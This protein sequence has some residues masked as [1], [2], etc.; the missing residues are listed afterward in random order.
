MPGLDALQQRLEEFRTAGRNL[1]LQPLM[2]PDDVARFRVDYQTE[3]VDE[4][5]Q[6]IADSAAQSEAGQDN[7]FI[8]TGHTGCGKSTLLAQVGMRLTQSSDY[9]IVMFSIA[10]MIE[11]SAVDHVN[12]LFSVAVQ[13]LDVAEQRSVKLPPGTKKELYR[14]LGEHAQ[15]ESKSVVDEIE[16]GVGTTVEG[17]IPVFFKFFAAIKNT[18]KINSLVRNDITVKFARKISELVAKINEIQAYVENAVNK[19]ILVII[20]DLDKLDLSVT[21]T[22]FSKNIRALLDPNLSIVYTIPIATLRDVAVKKNIQQ[23]IKKIHTM[24][25]AKFFKKSEVRDAKR[26]PDVTLMTVFEEILDRRLPDDLVEPG[27]KRQMILKS[28]GVLRELMRIADLCCDRAL[29]EIR[30]QIRKA[31][32]DQPTVLIDALILESVLTDMQITYSESLGQ[33]DYQLLKRIYA[34]FKPE[35][36]E[37][38]RFLDLLHS[39][40]ILEYRNAVQWFDLNPI[41]FDLLVQEAVLDG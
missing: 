17:G 15:T 4:L 9:F 34:E 26:S 37:S 24:P 31:L 14:W 2:N 22:I 41:V 38:Q 5:E 11:Q 10:D 18:L 13:L 25:V 33:K 6:A 29:Q 16:A 30:R 23:H 27:M 39:L 35:D 21:E 28:G 36:I 19:K 3:L 20:D 12:I 7:K 1:Q 40:Y 8:F 32:Y